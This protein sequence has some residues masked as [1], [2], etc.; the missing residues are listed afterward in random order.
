LADQY[1]AVADDSSQSAEKRQAAMLV[2]M[3]EDHLTNTEDLDEAM[4]H[5]NQALARFRELGD[6]VSVSD[7]ARLKIHIL[8]AQAEAARF[9]A[10]MVKHDDILD[11]A[12]KYAKE[13]LAKCKAAGDKRGEG[14]ML[15]SLTEVGLDMTGMMARKAAFEAAQQALTILHDLDCK[16]LEAFCLCK[17]SVLRWRRCEIPQ[18][19]KAAKDA[20]LLFLEVGDRRGEA[21]A[22]HLHGMCHFATLNFADAIKEFKESL[23]ILREVGPRRQEAMEHFIIADAYYLGEKYVDA[24]NAAKEAF[25]LFTELKD[26]RGFAVSA[27]NL[28]VRVYVAKGEEEKGMN[29]AQ[30]WLKKYKEAGA[31]RDEVMVRQGLMNAHLGAD[32]KGDTHAA[33]A[34]AEES[35]ELLKEMGE[36]QWESKTLHMMAQL[37]L[38]LENYSEAM[39][40]AEE[41]R[42]L[43]QETGDDGDEADMLED[44]EAAHEG[45]G[46]FEQAMAVTQKMKELY[47]KTNEPIREAM[48]ML[49][50]CNLHL[51]KPNAQKSDV[52]SALNAAE[53]AKNLFIEV[54]DVEGEA[55]SLS[56]MAEIYLNGGTSD[57][58]SEARKA[59]AL[60][61]EARVLYQKEGDKR[62]EAALL[63]T[64]A[65]IH[66]E[67][68]EPHDAVQAANDAVVLCK[69]QE[70]KRKQAEMLVMLS[71]TLVQATNIQANK[72]KDAARIVRK[73]GAKAIKAAKEAMGIATK[74]RDKSLLA[75][76]TY[77]MSE[78]QTLLGKYEE[79]AREAT[80]AMA[81]FVEAQDKSSEGSCMCLLGE[82]H[83]YN[84]NKDKAIDFANKAMACAQKAKDG[85][86]E[87]RAISLLSQIQGVP[88]YEVAM[89]PGGTPHSGYTVAV[90][91]PKKG[92]EP[93]V[94]K[95]AVHKIAHASLAAGE[96]IEIH[97]DTPL[98]DAGMD[99]LSSVAFRNSLNQVVGLALPAALMFDYPSQRA[100]TDHIIE[101]SKQ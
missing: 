61:A 66:L 47:Q 64:T 25:K 18:A 70:S 98:M 72:S 78:A 71:Q 93:R 58:P 75:T 92:L 68:E 52:I 73:N 91:A 44:L 89:A 97:M 38:Q 96:D 80:K 55:S 34:V 81:L 43:S 86:V 12:E 3:A 74:A 63:R 46:D 7:T 56:A 10:G 27:L 40:L 79:A 17:L 99:S 13:E 31:K 41:A 83:F 8:R 22:W 77:S 37:H 85:N 35:L 1:T 88:S 20:R 42:L 94:V 16:K 26:G 95:E 45:N 33:L 54:G 48:V 32:G 5:A 23:K 21:K 84:N 39:R 51:Q 53:E 30:E 2:S 28:I 24:Q 82:I 59:M 62:L 60:A 36:K 90:D 11:Q 9:T 76:A 4:K 29:L 14:A 57:K 19:K 65:R 101:V 15:L 50:V 69:K 67:L 6:V 100:I 49:R 87:Q